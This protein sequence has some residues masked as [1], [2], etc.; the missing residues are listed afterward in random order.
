MVAL[1]SLGGADHPVFSL[2]RMGHM[3]EQESR[4]T[5]PGGSFDELAKGLAGGT[6][7]R[8]KM[9]KMMGAALF[10]GAV[11]SI[12]GVALAKPKPGRCTKN[13]HCP[14]GQTCVG[15]QCQAAGCVV[16]TGAAVLALVRR[17]AQITAIA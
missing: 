7:S 9:L 5:N 10:G 13:A 4:H 2:E 6:L 1:A 17:G 14:A 8:G 3:S 12:P 15:G 16:G 11:A